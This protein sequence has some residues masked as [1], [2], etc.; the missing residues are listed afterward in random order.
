MFTVDSKKELAG[1]VSSYVLAYVA[2]T[3]GSKYHNKIP[4]R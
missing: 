1:P 2:D 3:E 4:A